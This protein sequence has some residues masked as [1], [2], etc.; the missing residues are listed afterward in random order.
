M[1]AKPAFVVTQIKK[2]GITGVEAERVMK[3]QVFH[4][5]VLKMVAEIRRSR[6]LA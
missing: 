5:P 1:L 6:P 4:L 3:R 2:N